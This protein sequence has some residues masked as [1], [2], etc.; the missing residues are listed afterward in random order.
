MGLDTTEA[1]AYFCKCTE[2]FWH[3]LEYLGKSCQ[4]Y[5][6]YS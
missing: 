4:D 6:E 5:H 3:E 2:V 1:Y